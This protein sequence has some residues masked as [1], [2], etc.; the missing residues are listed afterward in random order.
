VGLSIVPQE[1]RG[2][3]NDKINGGGV[4]ELK[5]K[6]K[7]KTGLKGLLHEIFDCKFF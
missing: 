3:S 2:L 6:Y 7:D 1:Q 4:L 5:Y